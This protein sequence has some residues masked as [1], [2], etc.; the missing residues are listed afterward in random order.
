MFA[1]NKCSCDFCLLVLTIMHAY[2]LKIILK[3]LLLSPCQTHE[4][5]ING[6]SSHLRFTLG[7]IGYNM[8]QDD[9]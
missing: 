9:R 5:L 6:K 7:I 4:L 1:T 8:L 2:V 3:G